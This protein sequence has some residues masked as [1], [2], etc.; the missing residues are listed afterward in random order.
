[1]I[2]NEKIKKD[3]GITELKLTPAPDILK[4]VLE[5]KKQNAE[6]VKYKNLHLYNE[7]TFFNLMELIM[8]EKL[9]RLDAEY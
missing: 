6:V 1:M 2:Y 4:N 7:A 3:R 5:L 9:N 8:I